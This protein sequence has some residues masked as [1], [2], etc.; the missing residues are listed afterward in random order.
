MSIL[1]AAVHE[2]GHI[3][4]A[5]L[6]RIKFYEMRLGIFGARLNT[7]AGMYSYKTELLLA[8]AG[9]FANFL[10]L[11]FAFPLLHF[12]P[13]ASDYIKLFLLS[14]AALGIMNLL[15]VKSFDGGRIFTC[16]FSSKSPLA[17]EKFLSFLSFLSI[18]TL[19]CVSL[20]LLLR[21]STSLSLFIFSVSLFAKIF[22]DS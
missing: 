22:I 6:L 18:F 21:F 5:R 14:S 2:S 11:L 1:A 9:P 15:P 19:W 20:Y 16:I 7:G 12:F 13:T 4:A 17:V 3:I 10:S 8:A